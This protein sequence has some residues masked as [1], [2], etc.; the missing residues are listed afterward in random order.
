MHRLIALLVLFTVAVAGAESAVPKVMTLAIPSNTASA[1]TSVAIGDQYNYAREIDAV[2]LVLSG[3]T[4]TNVVLVAT[5]GQHM[6]GVTNTVTTQSLSSNLTT[7]VFPRN[8]IATNCVER[9]NTD[10]VTLSCGFVWATNTAIATTVTNAI[11]VS[12]TV[13]TK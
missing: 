6:A 12:A 13:L 5:V 8:F 11:S 1:V 4:E 9:F 10:R 3:K 2:K 7:F